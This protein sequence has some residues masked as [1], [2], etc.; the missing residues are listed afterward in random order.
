MTKHNAR[1]QLKKLFKS[2][3]NHRQG[4]GAIS[5][6]GQTCKAQ[7]WAEIRNTQPF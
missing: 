6:Q 7:S 1:K 2:V 5:H 4:Y 3:Q